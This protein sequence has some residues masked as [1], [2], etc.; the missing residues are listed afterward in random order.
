MPASPKA[1]A[2]ICGTLYAAVIVLGIFAELYVRSNVVV[3]GNPAATAA[4]LTAH[5]TLW[6]AGMVANLLG[7]ALYIAVTLMLYVLLKPVDENVSLL[8]AFFSLAGCAMT[9]INVLLDSAALATVDQ[10]AALKTILSLHLP[11]Y[12][13]SLAFFG[14]YC[15][16]LGYLTFRSG[17]FPKFVGVLLLAGGP[18]YVINSC[19]VLLAPVTWNAVPF[20]ITVIS[21]VAELVLTLWLLFVGVNLREWNQRVCSVS[22]SSA[23]A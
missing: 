9:G 17:Y 3:H 16:L 20:D 5:E 7:G 13:V 8:A 6:R 23:A 11:G 10:P 22:P 1:Y 12:C 18:C 2:R 19:M 14:F 15:A 4:N 21:G